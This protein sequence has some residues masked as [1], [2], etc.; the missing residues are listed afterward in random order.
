M[1]CHRIH[2]ALKPVTTTFYIVHNYHSIP[3]LK[4]YSTS[5]NCAVQCFLEFLAFHLTVHKPA[6]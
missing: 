3:Q 2:L 5:N 6:M 4:I 1:Y